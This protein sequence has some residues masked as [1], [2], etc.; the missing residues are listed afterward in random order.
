M[1]Q[2]PLGGACLARLQKPK[3]LPE[4]FQILLEHFDKMKSIRQMIDLESKE[5]YSNNTFM[6]NLF[7][8]L[9]MVPIDVFVSTFELIEGDWS[10]DNKNL[11]PDS[12]VQD[13]IAN[14]R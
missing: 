12:F 8:Q 3:P 6:W 4:K 2:T 9:Q 10:N 14:Y 13:T 11:T 1:C 7:I 5:M